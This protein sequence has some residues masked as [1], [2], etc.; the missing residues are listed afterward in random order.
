MRIKHQENRYEQTKAE[1]TNFINVFAIQV[2][3]V[4]ETRNY[5]SINTELHSTIHKFE[6][7]LKNHF[8]APLG[9]YFENN[10]HP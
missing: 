7:F 8:L 9:M 10:K 4:T 3:K 2:F 6:S 5:V 1:L